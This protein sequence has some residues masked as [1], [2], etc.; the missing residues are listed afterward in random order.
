M[1][2][3]LV[4]S[5][6]FSSFSSFSKSKTSMESS[7]SGSI[8]VWSLLLR[9]LVPVETVGVVTGDFVFVLFF[10]ISGVSSAVKSI[11]EMSFL[12]SSVSVSV[13]VSLFGRKGNNTLGEEDE[14]NDDGEEQEEERDGEVG[15]LPMMVEAT[16]VAVVVVAVS[17]VVEKVGTVVVVRGRFVVGNVTSSFLMVLLFVVA[18]VNDV[19]GNKDPS[20]PIQQERY[21]SL[22]ALGPTFWLPQ[23]IS[24]TKVW[25]DDDDDD[26]DDESELSV[27]AVMRECMVG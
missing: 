6:S 21:N 5:M 20:L 19:F 11:Q 17:L 15:T 10:F 8:I 22:A 9:F 25:G 3:L 12:F 7:S 16:A 14:T 13:S 23:G 18:L 24:R 2:S 27:K 26:D 1:A 4:S